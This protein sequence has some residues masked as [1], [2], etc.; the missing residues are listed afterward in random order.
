V[1]HVFGK[2]SLLPALPT[3]FRIFLE[4]KRSYS[5]YTSLYKSKELSIQMYARVVKKR[6]LK[7]Q[8]ADFKRYVLHEIKMCQMYCSY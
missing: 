4:E 7:V 6:D 1:Q 3:P 5:G 8:R 2:Y